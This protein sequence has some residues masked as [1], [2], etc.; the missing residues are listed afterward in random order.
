MAGL[1][2]DELTDANFQR[3]VIVEQRKNGLQRITDLHPS[4][5][6]MNYPLIHSY[7]EERY[8]FGIQFVDLCNKSIATNNLGMRQY[9][10][11]RKQ[12]RLNEGH[13]LLQAGRLLHQDIVDGYMA[14]EDERF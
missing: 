5:M 10:C 2:I 13:T 14:I 7:G 11:F 8:R 12:Q 4:F 6:D 1:I 9:Y 3:D